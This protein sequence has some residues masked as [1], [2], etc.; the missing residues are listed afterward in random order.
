MDWFFQTAPAKDRVTWSPEATA[1][2][3]EI[4]DEISRGPRVKVAMGLKRPAIMVGRRLAIAGHE[5]GIA[6]RLDGRLRQDALRIPGCRS[7][8][9]R[10][11]IAV[12]GMVAVPWAA[13][14]HWRELAQAAANG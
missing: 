13:R 4:A 1:L 8:G 2:F 14:E 5:D 9:R 7:L 11:G 6:V 10:D 3:T 12:R